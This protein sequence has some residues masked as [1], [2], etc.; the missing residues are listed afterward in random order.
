MV[1]GEASLIKL[2]CHLSTLLLLPLQPQVSFPPVSLHDS[3][4]WTHTLLKRP[5]TSIAELVAGF[6]PEE[7]DSQVVS[8]SLSLDEK[9]T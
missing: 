6:R 9:S 7:C 1:V 3:T 4:C 8:S 2:P 5:S